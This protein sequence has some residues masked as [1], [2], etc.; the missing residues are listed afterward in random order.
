MRIGKKDFVSLDRF[1]RQSRQPRARAGSIRDKV[2]LERR[3]RAMNFTSA[4]SRVQVNFADILLL[5]A[6]VQ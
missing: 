4:F 1:R 6:G 2:K 3:P 5:L